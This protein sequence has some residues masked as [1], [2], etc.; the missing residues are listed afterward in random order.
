MLQSI[1][2]G[3]GILSLGTICL[4]EFWFG[5]RNWCLFFLKKTSRPMP[6]WASRLSLYLW[7]PAIPWGIATIVQSG[8]NLPRVFGTSVELFALGI[9]VFSCL[10]CLIARFLTSEDEKGLSS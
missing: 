4:L 1:V 3:I 5:A 6:H 8:K 10:L 9:L 7:V 2:R